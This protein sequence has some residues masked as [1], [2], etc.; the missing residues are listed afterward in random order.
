MKDN[1]PEI[2][3][4]DLVSD[5]ISKPPKKIVRWGTVV[6]F[7]VFI[8][9]ILLAWLFRYPDIITAPVIISKSYLTVEDVTKITG[10]KAPGN[11]FEYIGRIS[12]GIER[13]GKVY[14]GQTVNIKVSAFPYLEFGMLNGTVRSKTFDESSNTF[15]LEVALNQG[16]TTNYKKN[17]EFIKNMQG[18]AE[19]LTEDERFLLRIIYPLRHQITKMK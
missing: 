7:S 9:L 17:L 14:A 15:D 13:S 11:S 10:D 16:L 3:Y 5:I 4:S 12:L 18:T 8:L 2:L 6:I 1:K 19:I